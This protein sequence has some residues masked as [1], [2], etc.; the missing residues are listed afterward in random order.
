MVG[1]MPTSP[2]VTCS[3]PVPLDDDASLRMRY[4]CEPCGDAMRERVR[5]Q[6]RSDRLHNASVAALVGGLVLAS[7]VSLLGFLIIGPPVAGYIGLASWPVGGAVI[8]TVV[9]TKDE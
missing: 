2:C 6:E 4:Y 5:A 9:M 1:A 3:Q 7:V 8:F